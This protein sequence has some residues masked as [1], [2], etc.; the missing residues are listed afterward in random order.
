MA[1]LGRTCATP[2]CGHDLVRVPG[3][4]PA[5]GTFWGSASE[6]EGARLPGPIDA[7][8]MLDDRDTDGN[9][10]DLDCGHP[11]APGIPCQFCGRTTPVRDAGRTTACLAVGDVVLELP[12]NV[13]VVLG[14]MSD[15]AQVSV[16]FAAIEGES[17]LGV[18]RRH[19]SVTVI[20]GQA[21]IV[22]LRSLNGTWI[23]GRELAGT[24]LVRD[25]PV[26]VSLGLPEVGLA[27]D[28]RHAREGER[29]VE[30]SGARRE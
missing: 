22:D 3:L 23:E 24:A 12:E 17:S 30:W 26:R 6:L 13:D 4:C 9:G 16:A 14:R 18:S 8:E 7:R 2:G 19:A 21:R 25:L 15:W 11:G 20:G 5:C 27:V 1:E 29:V 10:R 28:V